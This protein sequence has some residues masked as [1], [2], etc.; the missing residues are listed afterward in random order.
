VAAYERAKRVF[1][2]AERQGR[3]GEDFH[4]EPLEIERQSGNRGIRQAYERE[5]AYGGRYFVA[6]IYLPLL[7]DGK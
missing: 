2:E 4:G 1:A 5:R 6:G 3:E 7:L